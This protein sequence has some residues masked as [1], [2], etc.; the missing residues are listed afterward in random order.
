V[1]LFYLRSV[2]APKWPVPIESNCTDFEIFYEVARA[3]AVGSK[4]CFQDTFAKSGSYEK[5]RR[6]TP[7]EISLLCSEKESIEHLFFSLSKS[8]GQNYLSF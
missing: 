5:K 6:T 8:C 4:E 2:T 3:H 7:D 1:A